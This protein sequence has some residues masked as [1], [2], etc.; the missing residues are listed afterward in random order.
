[1]ATEQAAG[2]ASKAR[3][4]VIHTGAGTSGCTCRCNGEI[5]PGGF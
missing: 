1:M 5:A 2:S 3:L 4:A